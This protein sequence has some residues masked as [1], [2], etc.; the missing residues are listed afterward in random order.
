M[1]TLRTK[2]SPTFKAKVALEALKEQKT[3][4]ELAGHYQ[5]HP[6]QIRHWKSMVNQ[7]LVDIF[8]DRRQKREQDKDQLIEELYRQIGR[9]KVELD[10]L[11]KKSGLV[12]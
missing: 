12:P 1:K 4:A 7:G 8:T 9:L 6:T 11:K 10:W 3:S 5:V 2:H